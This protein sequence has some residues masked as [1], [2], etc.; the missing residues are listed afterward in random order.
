MSNYATYLKLGHEYQPI[1]TAA[2]IAKLP[3]GIYTVKFDPRSDQV[4]F[5]ESK[6]THDQLVD[7]PGTAYDNV[8]ADLEYFFT[9]ECKERFKDVGLLP[10]MNML[11]YG[12]PGGGK[13]CIVNR[14][15]YRMIQENGIVLFNPPPNSLKEVFRVLDLLQPET[16]VLVIF[17]ELDQLIDS[18][19]EGPFLHVLDGEVQK[20]NAMFIGTTN[21]IDKIPK[22]IRRPGRFAIRMEVGLPGLE[23]RLHYCN[24]KLKDSTLAQQIAE[25]TENFNIDQLKD[26]IRA[27]YCMK[28]PLESVIKDLRTEFSIA[29][30]GSTQ[31]FGEVEEPL[32]DDWKDLE[33]PEEKY[34][35]EV[36]KPSSDTPNY[37]LTIGGKE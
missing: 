22:R 36:M 33:P 23:A 27:H 10:K 18:Y 30:A 21:Y 19:G 32:D 28:K 5:G 6:T 31:H 26:V 20:S 1:P 37:R 11:L 7:L 2:T 8:M 3:P 9:A 29:P 16:N 25:L 13:T 34:L 15:A 35:R 12:I 17:E 4:A 24:L 14:V